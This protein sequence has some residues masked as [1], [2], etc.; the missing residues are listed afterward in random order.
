MAS[1]APGSRESQEQSIKDRKKE[2]FQAEPAPVAP[3][4]PRKTVKD[5][6]REARPMPMTRVAKAGLWVAGV[7]VVLLFLASLLTSSSR[8]RH[9]VPRHR[10]SRAPGSLT[11]VARSSQALKGPSAIAW[12]NAPGR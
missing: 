5:Y 7:L 2:L 9:R 4:G 3:T 8:P 10:V 6:L 12:G 11:T 1:E